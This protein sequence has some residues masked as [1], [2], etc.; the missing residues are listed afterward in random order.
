[1][2]KLEDMFGLFPEYKEQDFGTYKPSD[3]MA[4]M[5]EIVKQR[6]TASKLKSK[7]VEEQNKAAFNAGVA[8]RVYNWDA[9]QQ[10]FL[11]DVERKTGVRP[12]GE[13]KVKL[14]D[15]VYNELKKATGKGDLN[16]YMSENIIK[17]SIMAEMQAS[18]A[19]NQA[20]ADKASGKASDGSTFLG[21]VGDVALSLGQSVV[22]LGEI[23]GRLVGANDFAGG[24]ANVREWLQTNKTDA[25]QA[26]RK[27]LQEAVAKAEKSGSTKE[28]V[29]A[30]LDMFKAQPLEFLAETI[31][32]TLGIGAVARVG[33]K[34]AAKVLGKEAAKTGAIATGTTA[35]AA[36]GLGEVKGN[37]Y[38]TTYNE[39]I[40]R[41][42]DEPKAKAMAEAA[43]EYSLK[44]VGQQAL[45]AG[46]GA[47]G[48]LTGP[49][50]KLIMGTAAKAGA[51]GL[52]ARAATGIA[53]EGGTEALQEGQ[54]KYAGNVAAIDAGVLDSSQAFRGVAGSAALGGVVGGT[55]GGVSGA[56]SSGASAAPLP[57]AE[58]I[59]EPPKSPLTAKQRS[60]IRAMPQEEAFTVYAATTGADLNNPEVNAA[61]LQEFEALRTEP[62]IQDGA[63]AKTITADAISG[64]GE[65]NAITELRET[66]GKA[67]KN[68][69][70]DGLIVGEDKDAATIA[71]KIDDAFSFLST[72]AS[73]NGNFNN[74]TETEFAD[75]L[76]N[77]ISYIE[78]V[79]EAIKADNALKSSLG[80]PTR[81]QAAQEVVKANENQLKAAQ[82]T[83]AQKTANESKAD[84]QTKKEQDAAELAGTKFISDEPQEDA[85]ER[86]SSYAKESGKSLD[87]VVKLHAAS[88]IKATRQKA[89]IK[90]RDDFAKD[91]AAVIRGEKLAK[92]TVS[93]VL[94][95]GFKRSLKETNEVRLK[96]ARVIAGV[97]PSSKISEDL[98]AI[99]SN[100]LLA[101][102]KKFLSDK[103]KGS[104]VTQDPKQLTEKQQAP[105]AKPQEM[106]TEQ[107]KQRLQQLEQNSK[108]EANNDN[109]KPNV[110][111]AK[112]V[113]T[114]LPAKEVNEPTTNNP[115]SGIVQ[116]NGE[117]N[118]KQVNATAARR[119][120]EVNQGNRGSST[121]NAAKESAVTSGD[122]GS[123][124]YGELGLKAQ[125]VLAK[126]ESN[127]IK[128]SA[129]VFELQKSGALKQIQDK[130]GHC[131]GMAAAA[132]LDGLGNMVIGVDG[133]G[134]GHAVVMR[135]GYTYDPTFRQWFSPNVYEQTGFYIKR[136]LSRNDVQSFI[137]ANNGATPNIQNLGIQPIASPTNNPNPGVTPSSGSA[138]R[139]GDSVSNTSAQSGAGR[140]AD[141]ALSAK[142]VQPTK[143]DLAQIPTVSPEIRAQ[144]I[145]DAKEA[146]RKRKQARTNAL[147]KYREQSPFLAWL[148]DNGIDAEEKNEW[149]DFN[150][151]TPVTGPLFRKE[152]YKLDI[153]HT[154]A[155]EDGY[156]SQDS[157][158]DDL[159]NL[160]TRQSSGASIYALYTDDGAT[161]AMQAEI[162][163]RAQF[164]E[165]AAFEEL[166][167]V[168]YTTVELDALE[169]IPWDTPSGSSKKETT[170]QAMEAMGF[171][172]QEI[173]D[174]I[175]REQRITQ[176]ASQSSNSAS[177][178]EAS[179]PREGATTPTREAEALTAPTRAEVLAQQA[180]R[181]AEAKRREQ[182]GDVPLPTRKVTADTP[183]MFNT[184][185]SVFDVPQQSQSPTTTTN[186][187]NESNIRTAIEGIF[188][189]IKDAWARI[190]KSTV[191][192]SEAEAKKILAD[193]AGKNITPEFSNVT[194]RGA[195]VR[196]LADNELV[197]RDR[198]DFAKLEKVGSGSDR[199][200]YSLGNGNVVKVAK[201]AR[202][203]LQNQYEGDYLLKGV[204][205]EV[206]ERGLNYVV[207]PQIENIKAS[208]LVDTFN[209]DGDTIGKAKASEMLAE[210]A[211]FSQ[212]DFD[213]KT[214]KLQIALE[215]YG[216]SDLQ[217]YDVLWN[218]FTA[219]RNWGYKDG[220]AWHTDGG[221][222]GGVSML[223]QYKGVKNLDDADFRTVYNV[224]KAIKKE[225]GD[226]DK[227]TMYSKSDAD[228]AQA[229]YLPPKVEGEQGKIYL[230][231]DRITKG[232]E[233]S[234]WLHEVGHKRLAELL[235]AEKMKQLY[236]NVQSWKNKKGS[237]EQEIFNAANERAEKSGDYE[238]EIIYYAI[239]ETAQRGIKPDAS[240]GT[241]TAA[242]W[243]AKVKSLFTA[244][245]R[246]LTGVA[247]D[248][249][250]SANDLMAMAYGAA[251]LEY[252]GKTAGAQ[253]DGVVATS[254][255]P[256]DGKEAA[257]TPLGDTKTVTVNGKEY[258]V[259]NSD[260]KPIHPTVEGVRNFVRW[261]GDSKVTDNGKTMAQGGKPLVVY[262]GTDNEF[263]TFDTNK[264][265]QKGRALG[266]GFYLTNEK[267]VAA[268]YGG[269]VLS[270]YLKSEN[271]NFNRGKK[272]IT[273][274]QVVK[275]I[276]GVEKIEPD[277]LSNYGDIDYEGRRSVLNSALEDLYDSAET[278]A[279]IISALINVGGVDRDSLFNIILDRT[280]KDGLIAPA[281]IAS[282]S[283]TKNGKIYVAYNSGQLKSA[284]GNTGD[285]NPANPDI[286]FSKI[287]DAANA[288]LRSAKTLAGRAA[289]TVVDIKTPEGKELF[290]QGFGANFR[291]ASNLARRASI[292]LFGLREIANYYES[293]FKKD[294]KNLLNVI[295][296]INTKKGGEVVNALGR[297]D[298]VIL[299]DFAALDAVTR[300]ALGK[301]MQLST[302][303]QYNGADIKTAISPEAKKIKA[304]Y[305]A[306]PQAAKNVYKK[307]LAE[308]G[309]QWDRYSAEVVKSLTDLGTDVVSVAKIKKELAD[310]KMQVYF[311]TQRFGNYVVSATEN[312][313][314][315]FFRRYESTAQAE[316]ESKQ[317]QKEN[318]TWK[319][320]KPTAYENRV[321][322]KFNSATESF[323]VSVQ[324]RLKEKGK[325]EDEIKL[326][327]ETLYG[328]L[329]SRL[330]K[331]T[332]EMMAKRKG[333][334]GADTD[335]LRST[336]S[337]MKKMEQLIS[338]TRNNQKLAKAIGDA[339]KHVDDQKYND[340][341]DSIE[342]GQVIKAYEDSV[343]YKAEESP[344]QTAVSYINSAGF[345]STMGFN[346]SSGLVN[347]SGILTM[348]TPQLTAR[349][350]AK[351]FPA[352]MKAMY[353]V[354]QK[355]TTDP[356][357]LTGDIKIVTDYAISI[358][359]LQYGE[360]R[361]LLDV[362]SG[363]G[364]KA[365]AAM[366]LAGRPMAWAE[367]MVN[368]TALLASYR[369]NI[370]KGAKNEGEIKAAK[371]DPAKIEAALENAKND[372]NRSN[373][374]SASINKGA[375]AKTPA[376]RVLMFLKGYGFSMA[377]SMMADVKK[378]LDSKQTKEE[379]R[380]AAKHLMGI[381]GAHAIISGM[382][383]LP[384]IAAF[385]IF[386][387]A[388]TLG[389][390][391]DEREYTV[392]LKEAIY[393][394]FGKEN[395]NYLYHGL[396][397][398]G[399]SGRISLDNL[400]IRAR[401]DGA[402][403]KKLSEDWT[404]Q[405]MGA[406]IGNINK[407]WRESVQFNRELE[408]LPTELAVKRYAQNLPIPAV[409]NIAKGAV[410][411]EDDGIKYGKDGRPINE[412]PAS[413]TEMLLQ[414][415]G[416]RSET[417]ANA[418]TEKGAAQT[419]IA[420]QNEQRKRLL[421]MYNALGLEVI[422]GNV[423]QEQLELLKD[424]I[425]LYN[426][427]NPNKEITEK[428][429][430]NRLKKLEENVDDEPLSFIKEKDVDMVTEEAPW[431]FAK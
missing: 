207:V 223:E 112:P 213:N 105:V 374:D 337:S 313:V 75:T 56:V 100:E 204:L 230:I 287:T 119:D 335:M 397:G 150:P 197:A 261:F 209:E 111:A 301:V 352:I 3:P 137:D 221:T 326:V 297:L 115:N 73:G 171:S 154:R 79:N 10:K 176:E 83:E 169:D 146:S 164:E 102:Y 401:M 188:G 376:G 51:K 363:L 153:L 420:K 278:D 373:F 149:K 430:N 246:K 256:F 58:F 28:E 361:E 359:K 293:S 78:Q 268:G 43:S 227:V 89:K 181:D 315:V 322:P 324:A 239:E 367:K 370:E 307:V 34:V 260:G 174:E 63:V 321:K 216:F 349:H 96:N 30:Y 183:D 289:A 248:I 366:E 219:K 94:K 382:T 279:D 356:E 212:R 360:A 217:N 161:N 155:I 138:V 40:A 362:A 368:L 175:A 81:T 151:R 37:Q 82:Q 317:L 189:G 4:Q 59:P 198:F 354:G 32:P 408:T 101:E 165:D 247:S 421:E 228:T 114:T 267:N 29:F 392:Q 235:G 15:G 413:N 285:F 394:A 375:I 45:G 371:A 11:D 41:G 419:V 49:L 14:L 184:Q 124:L 26:E 193:A 194:R 383:G 98:F 201:T 280:G 39:A 57:D 2:A 76:V 200:V 130:K 170:R 281:E 8:A 385:P 309:S 302:A 270:L 262:H 231:A 74:Y 126:R 427:K 35:G 33:G 424:Q 77:N 129:E 21:G 131:Y 398:E 229:F 9:Y 190:S 7:Q 400:I 320:T 396:I 97:R 157:S 323:I 275:I 429:L 389:D 254:L 31:G 304:D 393:A 173:K 255:T 140:K 159:Y 215:K 299:K 61:T 72:A 372:M 384:F 210:L 294:G 310:N 139:D 71:T 148:L 222:I 53:I 291:G 329:E 411:F 23:G 402:D 357:K 274:Q 318:P 202:G 86:L 410:L 84:A 12:D 242:G 407:A 263:Y 16:T 64:L 381:V 339:K 238:G 47:V 92:P 144:Q 395:A 99:K 305:N 85:H 135:D 38:E 90:L 122:K 87:E 378:V 345:I 156:L 251:K 348:L 62:T 141:V 290:K 283:S 55:L 136:V 142:A 44:N 417:I 311:A 66:L 236:D 52:A 330:V 399:L 191:I 334:Q 350:G 185:G 226:A 284:T 103:E 1:M 60:D 95:S 347:T 13:V 332:E 269:N 147:K 390:A 203:L 116:P 296:D 258:S 192:V 333:I 422:K 69:L 325:S 412:I 303:V 182:G 327:A 5:T 369:L 27:K 316:R 205:P 224:S 80:E 199:D 336:I 42:F 276:D 145:A 36:F 266:S 22:G 70:F 386:L 377:M 353:E 264:I 379:R 177:Q 273:K 265:G 409:A 364:T 232:Q 163:R 414:M 343:Y 415:V 312:G 298:K 295:T 252:E 91:T 134:E 117:N 18:A 431:V 17:P 106:T 237:V 172:E 234:V 110:D 206:S 25:S 308:H 113:A 342:A 426:E 195:E 282:A 250:L 20:K 271:P 416:I 425:Q 143:A 405:L 428:V 218:D 48:V 331:K 241:I 225:L 65:K 187:T 214:D 128:S 365:S 24:A 380:F 240:K 319:V 306:L 300:E 249:N 54:G 259:F 123:R 208:D 168:T 245:L 107:L 211:K 152:G 288:K 19:K 403:N 6:D 388:A 358:G 46:L 314:D 328:A 178:D 341:Y 338:A 166:S 257:K 186:P 351:A 108:N 88:Y 67:D 387:L 162:D 167:Q 160:I 109:T 418:Q 158:V 125:A 180:Q 121:G 127:A 423:G 104:A 233:A 243:L 355:F 406:G 344:A 120:G 272:T 391:D 118:G 93:E 196:N 132:S 404:N 346:V 253:D 179:Q 50:D 292:G 277:F 286:R 340:D 220:T 244:A 68:T 133:L